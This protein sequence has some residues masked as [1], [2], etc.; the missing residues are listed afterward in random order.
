MHQF[1][2]ILL[3]HHNKVSQSHTNT[4]MRC[5]RE[6][7]SEFIISKLL[8]GWLMAIARFRHHYVTHVCKIVCAT[9]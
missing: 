2:F 9:I 6:K 4:Q 7:E 3:S 8:A 1:L 5:V